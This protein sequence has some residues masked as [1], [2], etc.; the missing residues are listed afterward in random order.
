VNIVAEHIRFSHAS[1]HEPPREVFR[2][3]TLT[4]AGG[5]SVGILGREG[6]GKTTLLSILGGL[7]PPA[8]GSVRIDG[9]DPH[10]RSGGR[11]NIRLRMGFTFQFPE[12]QF[13]CHT[14]AEEF[15][16]LLRLR[17]VPAGEIAG[18]TGE[19]LEL[20]G[21]DPRHI[22]ERSPFSLSLGES[23]RLALSLLYAIRPEAALCDEPTAGMDASGVSCT[24]NV[25]RELRKAGTTVIIATHDVDILSEIA[26]RV[27]I[28]GDLGIAA[29]GKSAAILFD[30]RL[31]ARHGYA[32]PESAREANLR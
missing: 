2:D 13:L 18:R 23:R 30:G 17:G 24:L 1:R 12:E 3:L 9:I 5:D 8:G 28:L 21:L 25:I 6:S 15:S 10:S 22:P 27:V 26:G 11:E 16:G 4:V 32:L 14:V 29:D 7:I 20:M 31:L 19:A